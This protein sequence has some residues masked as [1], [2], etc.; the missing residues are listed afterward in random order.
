MDVG[1]REFKQHLSEYLDRVERGETIRI[2]DRGRPKVLLTPMPGS[3]Q[4]ERGIE[5]GW[6]RPPA[7]GRGLVP[8]E[9]MRSQRRVLDVLADDRGA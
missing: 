2:T 4:L 3:G 8:V 6:I 9:P 1:V 5:E 7:S